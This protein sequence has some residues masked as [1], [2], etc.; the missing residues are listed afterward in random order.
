M[1]TTL[2]PKRKAKQPK[3]GVIARPVVPAKDTMAGNSFEDHYRR[4]LRQDA[5]ECNRRMRQAMMGG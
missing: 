4:W 5:A 3:P 2:E 1:T